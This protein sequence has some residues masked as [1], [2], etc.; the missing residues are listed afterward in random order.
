MIPAQP[1][2]EALEA[3]QRRANEAVKGD[4]SHTVANLAKAEKPGEWGGRS[5]ADDRVSAGA[6]VGE[7]AEEE[8]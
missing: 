5:G 2:K 7:Q 6:E 8:Q 1:P 4:H 3:R